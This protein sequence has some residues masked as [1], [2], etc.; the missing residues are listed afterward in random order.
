MKEV[1]INEEKNTEEKIDVNEIVKIEQ[2]PKV[3]SQLEK[4]GEIIKKKTSDLDKLE[5]TEANKQEVKSRR[6]EINNTLALL[7]AKKKEIKNKLLEPYNVFEE[8]YNKECKEKLQNASSILTEKINTIEVQQKLEKEQELREFA[9]EYF[10]H[11]MI[12]GVVKFEDIGLNITLSASI[13]S[14]KEQIKA[15]CERISNDLI[16]IDLEEYKDEIVIEYLKNLDFAKSKI[17]VIERHRQ[18][19]KIKKREEE[20]KAQQEQEQEVVEKV[21]EV[22]EEIKPPVEII[23]VETQEVEEIFTATFTVKTTKT[24]LK[25]LK[26]FMESEEIEYV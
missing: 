24:K 17:L 6:T 22:V 3:F 13:K 18:L 2:M 14:L 23:D 20:L 4:I 5:C 26:N 9:D 25:A 16:M 11:Y 12:K 10:N 15:F 21:E 19:E 8:K 1:N 7:E